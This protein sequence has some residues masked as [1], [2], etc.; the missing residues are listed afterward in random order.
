MR[1]AQVS[2]YGGPD[3]I[4]ILDVPQPSVGPGQLLVRAHAVGVGPWD[5]LIRE[6]HSGVPQTL[7]LIPGSDVAGIVDVLGPGVTGFAVGD[8]VYGLTN[9]HFTGGY[10]EYA[11][12]STASMARKPRNLSFI[13]AAS[14]PVVAVTAWQMLFDYAR[15]VAGQKVLVLGAAGNVGAYAVQLARHAG[16]EVFATASSDDLD[17]IRA[18]GAGIA[19]DYRHPRFEDFTQAMD[20]VIDTVGGDTRLQSLRVLKPGGIL[21]SAVY[22]P[23]PT[24]EAIRARVRAVTFIVNVTTA[25][26]TTI[27]SLFD[28]GKLAPQ[29]GTVL[30]LADA[31][32]TH[33]MLAGAP[34]PRGKIVL[35]LDL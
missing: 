24:E 22:S 34:H 8:Q 14:V 9:G 12:V 4:Q 33:R 1:A 23:L 26:L 21:V 17:Y 3:V 31:Q 18:L 32:L 7:P 11:A 30:P 16:L 28:S 5:A 13:E 20:I 6:G 27:T 15:A 19:I 10:A 29:V 25:Q 35:N 2:Q